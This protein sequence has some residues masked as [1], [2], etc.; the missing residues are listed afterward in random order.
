MRPGERGASRESQHGCF[1]ALFPKSLAELRLLSNSLR[2]I[3]QNK[4]YRLH[5]LFN[6]LAELSKVANGYFSFPFIK[7]QRLLC[8]VQGRALSFAHSIPLAYYA[9]V[10]EAL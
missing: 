7:G 6:K 2:I 8:H 1:T 3:I 9:A 5:F 10:I 4:N